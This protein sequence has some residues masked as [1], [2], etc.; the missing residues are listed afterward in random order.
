M[1]HAASAFF[2][3]PYEESAILTIDGAGEWTTSMRAYGK[4]NKITKLGTVDTPHSLGAFYQ[5]VSRHLG[6]KYI[7]GP[8]KLMGLASYGN[9]NSEQYHKMKPLSKTNR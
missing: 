1:C 2:A 9:H 8:G 5:A 4:G 6:F 3:S 7:E